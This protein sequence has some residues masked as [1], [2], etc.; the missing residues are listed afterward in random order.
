MY[1]LLSCVHGDWAGLR[2][3]VM[4]P[5]EQVSVLQQT[6]LLPAQTSVQQLLP[7]LLTWLCVC[8]V[9]EPSGTHAGMG[10]GPTLLN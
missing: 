9:A 5:P 3:P 2:E 8:I 10:S 1:A 6:I 4:Q 7:A